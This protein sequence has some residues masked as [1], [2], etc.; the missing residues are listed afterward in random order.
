MVS[1]DTYLKLL[2]AAVLLVGAAGCGCVVLLGAGLVLW[3]WGLTSWVLG[4]HFV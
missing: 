1:D 4:R 3:L 2:L